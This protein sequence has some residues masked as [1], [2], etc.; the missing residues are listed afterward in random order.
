MNRK[1]AKHG[2]IKAGDEVSI[3]PSQL[4]TLEEQMNFLKRVAKRKNIKGVD[5][6]GNEM[7]KL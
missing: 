2:W 1:N 3:N 7:K 4:F 6:T 5:L